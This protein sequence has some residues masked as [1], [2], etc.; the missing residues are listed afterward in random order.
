MENWD[1]K[2]SQS[3]TIIVKILLSKVFN[4]ALLSEKLLIKCTRPR[5]VEKDLLVHFTQVITAN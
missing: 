2:Q 5:A 1:Q 4:T 3:S